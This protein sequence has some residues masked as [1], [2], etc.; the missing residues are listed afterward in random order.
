MGLTNY[1][2][3][4][5]ATPNIGGVGRLADMFAADNIFFV[6]GVLG[7]SANDGKSPGSGHALDSITNAISAASKDAVIYVKPQTTIASAQTYYRDNIT[8]PLT[9]PNL[10]I[11]GCGAGGANPNSYTGVQLKVSAATTTGN[12]I[13]VNGGGAYLENMRLTGN[14]MTG[15][16][17]IVMANTSATSQPGGLHVR[18]CLFEAP[19]AVG[20]VYPTYLLGGCIAL[21][22]CNYSLIEGNFFYNCLGSIHSSSTYGTQGRV[23]IRGNSFVGA[24]GSRDLDIHLRPGASTYGSWVAINHNIFGDGLPTGGSTNLF[25]KIVGTGSGHLMGNYFASTA[26]ATEYGSDGTDCIIPTTYFFAGNYNEDGLIAGG[27]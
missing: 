6:D 26:A 4:I 2:N 22:S 24:P 17:A 3:G 12:L 16:G 23:E 25:I 8:I 9:K 27:T 13:T 14:A 1:P 19:V 18:G 20:T 7:D 15:T 5:F 21:G 11:I 10:S